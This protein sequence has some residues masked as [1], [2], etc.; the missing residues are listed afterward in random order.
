MINYFVL[1]LNV[2]PLLELDGYW[3]LADWLRMPDLRPDALSFVR[4]TDVGQARGAASAF[5]RG[6]LGLAV[7]G[8]VGVAFTVFCLWSAWFFWRRVFGE[9]GPALLHAGPL[10]W[11]GLAV[12]VLLLGGP[13]LRGARRGGVS[14]LQALRRRVAGHRFRWQSRWRVEAA[15]LIDASAVFGDLPVDGAQRARRPGRAAAG[16]ASARRSSGRASGRTPATSCGPGASRSSRRTSG[17][18][19]SRASC[20]RSAAATRSAS[21]RCCRGGTR[22]ATVRAITAAEVF[23]IGKST[24]DRL[25]ADIAQRPGARDEPAAVRRPGGAAAVRPP[26]PA[27]RSPPSPTTAAGSC[28]A[29]RG[30]RDRGRAR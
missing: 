29:R 23:V 21:S 6:E 24:V 2:V 22:T 14:V 19:A 7:Y 16:R 17:R 3:I 1:F 30:R 4:R 13:A 11:L 20:A 28:R 15:E 5:S 27:A 12:L 25:L 9:H 26:R 18:A 10:G 8:I